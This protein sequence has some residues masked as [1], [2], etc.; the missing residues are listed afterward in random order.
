MDGLF[1]FRWMWFGHCYDFP[2][3]VGIPV[4][5]SEHLAELRGKSSTMSLRYSF[6]T[7]MI[8]LDMILINFM[9]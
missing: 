9:Q 7:V 8:R 6:T 4:V 5:K 3:Y 2:S 1:L